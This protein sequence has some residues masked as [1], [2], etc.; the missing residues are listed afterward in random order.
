M[1]QS[2]APPLA[3]LTGLTVVSFESRLAAPMADLISR[4]GGIPVSAPALREIPCTEHAEAN[5]FA[6][7]LLAGRIDMVVWL[8]GVGARALLTAVEGTVSRAECLAALSRIPTIALGPKPQAVLRELGIPITLA[9]PEPN[10]WREILTAIDSAAIPLLGRRVA[11][12]EYGRSNPELIAG[13]QTRGAS[14][15]RVPVYQWALPE[16]CGP[17]RQAIKAIANQ[18]VD[19]V[20]FTTAVQADHLLQVAA[21]DGLEE[22]LRTGLRDTVVASIGPTC[23][24]ALREHGLTVDLEPEHPKMGHLVQTAA[25]HAHVLRRIK[26]AGTVQATGGRRPETGGANLL[27]ESPFLKACRLEPAPYTPIWIM[28]QAGRYLQE[29]REIRGKLSFLELCH[30]PDLAAE[31]TVTAAE[32]LGVDAAIIFGDILLVV[33]P[34]GV[35][36][37][38]TKGDGPVIHHPIRCGADLKRLQPVDVQGSLSFLFEAVRLAR[39]A[40]PANIPL[41]GFAGAPFTLASYLIEGRGSRQYQQ[42]KTL[43]YRDP[44][45]WHALMER[46]SDVVS[47]YLNGQIAAGVQVVQLFDSWVGCLSPDDYREFVL[48]HT[49]RAIAR[50]VPGV[51][52]I[53][54]GT[55]TTSLLPL[56]REAGGNVIG[57]DWRVDLGEA[58]AGLGYEVG[59]QGNL[60]P[61]ALFAE[62]DKIRRQADR[63]LERAAKRPGHIFN[64]GHGI[65]PQTPVDHLRVLIDY[66]HEAT[67]R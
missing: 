26:R 59:V 20:L 43:M 67:A 55:D 51:P 33:E 8:T 36:L 24:K 32:R 47:D 53:H 14:V 9:V 46:L 57:L 22:P 30:R 7:A 61:V 17:L 48:P 63:I 6:K 35:G 25:R 13:L 44:A 11:V 38:F 34:M 37:E 64:L 45:A 52:V 16:D 19:L 28:R 2:V 15:L 10:T 62:P 21:A 65:L 12:Q 66:V 40:L 29:Y 23:S 31:V 42:I 60:D 18:Q 54:F 50:L 56:I 27:Q 4:Q 58:W 1:N 39:A 49:K 5:E 3:G 41:I